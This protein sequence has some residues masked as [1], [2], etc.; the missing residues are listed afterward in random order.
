M[1][2]IIKIISICIFVVIE[3]VLVKHFIISTYF[4]MHIISET[5]KVPLVFH[6]DEGDVDVSQMKGKYILLYFEGSTSDKKSMEKEHGKFRK[7]CESRIKNDERVKIFVVRSKPDH[8]SGTV[9]TTSLEANNLPVPTLSLNENSLLEQLKINV[10]PTVLIIDPKYEIK[11][12]GPS[13]NAA[14][15]CLMSLTYGIS[16]ED[17]ANPVNGN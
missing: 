15:N 16:T 4:D 11:F 2:K 17:M 14:Y 8:V 3:F 5:V 13:L 12:R 6:G 10:L 1:K 7:I 9:E